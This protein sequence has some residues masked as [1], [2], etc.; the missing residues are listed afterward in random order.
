MWGPRFPVDVRL[1]ALDY[2]KRFVDPVQKIAA[3]EM[4]GFEGALGPLSKRGGWAILYNPSVRSEGRINY[5]LGHEFGHYLCHRQQKPAG[6]QC[7]ES[8]VLG[9]TLQQ[10]READQFASYLLMPLDDFRAQ[11]GNQT[12]TLDLLQHCSDRYGVSFTAAAL[13]W[14]ESTRLCAA[15]VVATNGFVLWCRRS[16]AAQRAR[17]YFP[18][19]LELPA[20]SL[21]AQ[22]E[23]ALSAKGADLPPGVW[24]NLPT[25]EVAIFADHYEMTISL[26]VFEDLDVLPDGWNEEEVEDAFDR[27]IR[28]D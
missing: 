18:S 16:A 20:G 17:I 1:I 11:V 24:W 23:S 25:R 3:A 12:M 9:A 5:T 13:K 27:F 22:G 2:S 28:S 10:E 14:L 26:L 4:P 6:F 8:D 7:G 21:A 19:G 15:V